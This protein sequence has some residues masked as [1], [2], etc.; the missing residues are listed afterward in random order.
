[1][2]YQA[3]ISP[4]GASENSESEDD[5]GPFSEGYLKLRY[6]RFQQSVGINVIDVAPIS[7][8]YWL[9]IA[10]PSEARRQ[11]AILNGCGAISARLRSS[12]LT[13]SRF[14]MDDAEIESARTRQRWLQNYEREGD[15]GEQQA[16]ERL[17]HASPC[18]ISDE[19]Q[20]TAL[21]QSELRFHDALSRAGAGTAAG[22]GIFAARSPMP[23]L[24][25]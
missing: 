18:L 6:R 24:P 16:A 3:G 2:P 25:H 17:S 8:N 22:C 1:M 15:D 9:D 12:P 13:T 21:L 10:P 11:N 19:S 14:A 4:V 23:T 20:R 7:V 5:G